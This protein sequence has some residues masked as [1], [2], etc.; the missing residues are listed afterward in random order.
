MNTCKVLSNQPQEL[1]KTQKISLV[2]QTPPLAIS[3]SYSAYWGGIAFPG[4][5][6]FWMK[7]PPVSRTITM[8]PH[9]TSMKIEDK[10]AQ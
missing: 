9:R 8:N 1:M 10:I 6:E 5:F 2:G 4:H 3:K 7:A